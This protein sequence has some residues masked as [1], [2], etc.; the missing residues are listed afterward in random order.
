MK[1]EEDIYS[2]VEDFLA[3]VPGRMCFTERMKVYAPTCGGKCEKD[4]NNLVEKLNV[5]FG[6][7]TTYDNCTGCWFDEDE[8]KVECEPAKVIELAHNCGD[9]ET[10]RQMMDAILE[11]ATKS[12][13]KSMSVM[14]GY[15]YIAKSKELLSKYEEAARGVK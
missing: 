1:P 10:L 9:Q 12:K 13:Q 3:S 15:F 11:Y 7:S 14:N 6:G 2:V 8:N 4:V 5:I